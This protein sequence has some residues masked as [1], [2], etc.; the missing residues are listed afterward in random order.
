MPST[1]TSKTHK[2][3][4]QM[5]ADTRRACR[6]LRVNPDQETPEERELM[7]GWADILREVELQEAASLPGRPG[8]V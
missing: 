6:A 5:A 3:L 4:M 7:Q 8:N 1:P 2:R